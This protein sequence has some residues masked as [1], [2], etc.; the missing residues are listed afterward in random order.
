MI[1]P[2][3]VFTKSS[4]TKLYKEGKRLLVNSDPCPPAEQKLEMPCDTHMPLPSANKAAHS[5]FEIQSRHQQKSKTGVS[6]A[7]QIIFYTKESRAKLEFSHYIVGS[8]WYSQISSSSLL[9]NHI[10]IGIVL[11][12]AKLTENSLK[13][14]N[15]S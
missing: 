14:E 10:V 2:R 12:M 5:R 1:V 13:K 7:P 9:P 11:T 6:V 15:W 4:S 8:L 3:S